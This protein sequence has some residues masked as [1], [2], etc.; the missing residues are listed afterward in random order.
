MFTFISSSIFC[1]PFFYRYKQ[2]LLCCWLL[3]VPVLTTTGQAPVLKQGYYQVT[4]QRPDGNDIVFVL[5][6]GFVQKQPVIE[7]INA[8]ERLLVKNVVVRGDS[9]LADMPAF[10]SWFRVRILPG[11][12]WQGIWERRAADVLLT[13]PL[14][15]IWGKRE[16]F[17]VDSG[18]AAYN[19]TGRWEVSLTRP[20]GTLRPAVAIFSQKGNRLTGTFLTP[21]GDYRYLE[22]IVTGK[23]VVLSCFDGSHAFSFTATV[24][25]AGTIRE[26]V[27][28]N[29]I[30]A[31][32][33][34]VAVRNETARLPEVVNPA[35]MKPGFTKL[36]FSFKD[37][38]GQTVSLQDAR[39]QNKVVIVQI[40][41]SWCP[42]CMDETRFLSDYYNKNRERGVEVV[43]LAYEYTTD[44]QRSANSLRK[45]QQLFQV[46]YPLL[47]T[48]VAVGDEQRTEKTLPQLTPI[49]S[50]PTTIYI[51]KKGEVR[52]V[53]N[54]FYGPATG[55]L[56]EAF[57]KSFEQRINSLLAE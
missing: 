23:K 2:R 15:A 42:N 26:G 35:V 48:G 44:F 52:E 46:Q 21:S 27:F 56:H 47:I 10:E 16:R 34:W 45:F 11:G 17:K 54:T 41:G 19:I 5:K 30:T 32:E 14:K 22:G 25:D 18:S 37:I 4:L 9:L 53:H 29:G 55:A 40:M 57:R 36:D 33:N 1:N 50:F 3:L 20:N 38:N 31:K 49:R 43:A 7:I 12:N 24:T 6:A 8:E 13:M 39:F 51:D 28:Y